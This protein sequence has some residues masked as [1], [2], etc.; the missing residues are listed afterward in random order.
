MDCREKILAS[1]D[2]AWQPDEE[3]SGSQQLPAWSR[4]PDMEDQ[5]EMLT[6][7]FDRFKENLIGYHLVNNRHE[8]LDSLANNI[9]S[10]TFAQVA[11]FNTG[12]LKRVK[13]PPGLEERLPDTHL[14]PLEQLDLQALARVDAGLTPLTA[15]IAQTGTLVV[16]GTTELQLACSLLPRTHLCVAHPSQIFPDLD[17]FLT[18]PLFDPTANHVLISGPS[19]TADIEKKL[20]MGVHGP[21]RVSIFLLREIEE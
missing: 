14:I 13:L 18:S 9:Y 21:W 20:V 4:V 8:L 3:S 10:R 17:A 1:L 16:S 7:L 19:R 2:T 11:V 6:F 5:H 12:L 15:I